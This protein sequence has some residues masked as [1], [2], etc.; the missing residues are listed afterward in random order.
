MEKFRCRRGLNHGDP[1]ATEFSLISYLYLRALRVSV[2]FPSNQQPFELALQRAIARD[3]GH[4][5]HFLPAFEVDQGRD[6][7]DAVADGSRGSRR[8]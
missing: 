2:V 4:A 8:R 6:A 7:H 3:A 1:E 5:I